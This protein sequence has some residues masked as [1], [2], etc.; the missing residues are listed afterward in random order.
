MTT[1][2]VSTPVWTPPLLASDAGRGI[3]LGWSRSRLRGRR[4]SGGVGCLLLALAIVHS[5]GAAE[6]FLWWTRTNHIAERGAVMNTVVCNEHHEFI[7]QPPSDWKGSAET[8]EFRM[9]WLSPDLSTLLR[10]RIVPTAGQTRSGLPGEWRQVV[11]QR[12]AD[13]RIVEEFNCFTAG[14]TGRAFDL[15]QGEQGALTTATRFALVP[16][17]AGWVELSLSAPKD[18]FSSQMQHFTALLNSFQV[19]PR[20]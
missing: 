2:R 11:R 10:V 18:G 16:Y 20:P 1:A 5:V 13:A 19:R 17:P 9:T 6:P 14:G 15:E 12:F 7:F 8:N 3:D 4:R